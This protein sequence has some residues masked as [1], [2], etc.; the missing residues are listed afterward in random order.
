M[1]PGDEKNHNSSAISHYNISQ[2][3]LQSAFK[4]II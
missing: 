1:M 2:I 4:G 3:F